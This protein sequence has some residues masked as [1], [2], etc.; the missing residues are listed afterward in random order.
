MAL[1]NKHTSVPGARPHLMPGEVGHNT[2][3]Q[4]LHLRVEG[5]PERIHLPAAASGV[6]PSTGPL[7]AP[8]TRINGA[9][10]WDAALTPLAV[11]D[12]AVRVDAPQSGFSVPGL[13]MDGAPIDAL[14]PAETFLL[15]PF[16]VASDR[17]RLSRIG[18]WLVDS[19]SPV[20]IGLI[21]SQDRLVVSHVVMEP[22]PGEMLILNYAGTLP[23]GDY[24]AFLWTA[25]ERTVR[26]LPGYRI[27]QGF[28]VQG[29]GGPPRFVRGYRATGDFLDGVFL[30]DFITPLE[31]EYSDGPGELRAVW[32][33]WSLD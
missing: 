26:R 3:D 27:S 30:N 33:D 13:V 19:A 8:L 25:G 4:T 16:H 2:A 21:D 18:V 22:T 29:A 9:L 11:V 20:R 6:A 28:D 5:R 23:Q 10:T 32:L 17:I 15:E 7:G 31:P 24:R 14:L 1:Q 12:G